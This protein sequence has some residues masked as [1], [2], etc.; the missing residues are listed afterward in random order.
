MI[1][2]K[3]RLFSHL[4]FKIHPEDY[5]FLFFSRSVFDIIFKH[6]E[7]LKNKVYVRFDLKY[8]SNAFD[9]EEDLDLF[10][11][12]AV[13]KQL[14][15]LG[16]DCAIV[17]VDYEKQTFEQIDWGDIMEPRIYQQTAVDSIKIVLIYLW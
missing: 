2:Y 7:K 11:A 9:Q 10:K 1:G 4:P 6:L 13:H 14:T 8:T 12:R 16:V 3:I 5:Y 17:K 15:E